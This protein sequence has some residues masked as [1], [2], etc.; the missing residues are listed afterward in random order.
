MLVFSN[1]SFMGIPVLESLYGSSSIFYNSIINFPFFIFLFTYGVFRL[2][3]GKQKFNLKSI[4]T[5]GVISALVA[6]VIFLTGV[7]LPEIIVDTCDMVGGITSPLSM[8][9]LGSTVAMYPLGKTLA[10]WR[11]YIF[12]A[13]RLALPA[14][15][16]LA[17]RLLQIDSY[18]TGIVTISCA[19]P[20]ASMVL[21]VAEQNGLDTSPGLPDNAGI[22]PA[23]GGHNPAVC[24]AFVCLRSEKPPVQ[25]LH[26]GLFE[27]SRQTR[28]R[29]LWRI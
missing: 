20:V 12:S 5:P 4:L 23:L 16:L 29:G 6:L 10:D 21:M 7:Q 3:G 9:V 1:N 18:Y 13:F 24:R 26:R 25:Q 19:M 27:V 17:C 15:A 11:S 28:C 8:M 2:S 14:L 22:D